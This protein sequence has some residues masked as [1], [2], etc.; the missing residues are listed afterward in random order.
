MA[1][2]HKAASCKGNDH[3]DSCWGCGE[4]GHKVSDCKRQPKCF[5]CRIGDA[6]A[7]YRTGTAQC[8]A[9]KTATGLKKAE[10]QPKQ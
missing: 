2:G 9:F 8:T 7:A 3:S 10:R 5:I 4:K 6:Q 1:Y